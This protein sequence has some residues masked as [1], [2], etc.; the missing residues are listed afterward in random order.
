VVRAIYYYH[1]VVLEWGDIGYNLL[2]DR[3]GNIY[4]GRYG[5]TGVVG[6][7][8]YQYNWGSLGVA[9][10][11]NFQESTPS[12]PMLSKLTDLLAWRSAEH[13]LDPTATQFFVD[14]PL[15]VLMGHRDAQQTLCPGDRAY[16]QLPALRAQT[17]AKMALV[18][19]H[20]NL[21]APRD[22]QA[23]RGVVE[24]TIQASAA[25][26]RVDYYLDDALRASVP[27]AP[28]LWKWNTVPE[29]AGSHRLRV[30]AQNAAGQREGRATLTVDNTP[31]S[32]TL[33]APTWVSS[34]QIALT[35]R[36][37]DATQAQFS[38][39]WVWEG[40]ALYHQVL[41]GRMV[42]DTAATNGLAW[43]GRVG[44]DRAGV[45]YGPY[46]CGIP[47]WRSYQALFRLKTPSRAIT[48][49]LATLDVADD[50]GRRIYA[51]RV[52]N[53]ADFPR[54]NV[55]EEFAL[56]FTYRDRWPACVDSRIDDGLEF[57]TAFRATGDLTLDRVAVF[58]SPQPAA[59]SLPWALRDEEGA[60]TLLVRLLDA[61]GNATERSF[62]ITL[63]KTAPQWRMTGVRT[64]EV[65]DTLSGLN[66][67][68][69]AYALSSD[70]GSSWGSWQTL[71]L[72]ATAG[73]TTPLSLAVPETAGALLR[74]RVADRAG[75]T[76]TT[77]ASAPVWLP[78]IWRG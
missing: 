61:A 20:L 32:G 6:G 1:A 54:E 2:V 15:P 17:L 11:G 74:L 25:I 30:V 56:P 9:L 62:S 69:A 52:L 70:G 50:Q 78:M 53:G 64:V 22:G 13:Y 72:S 43:Q 51:Q 41:S 73:V 14:Q 38:N 60:Q 58:A 10:V 65:Q 57:R 33:T 7:H 63:D 66:P 21:A 19:P 59:A 16:A 42:S 3:L 55:Y 44:G 37:S 31:P 75:N 27:S 26:S 46:S 36:E 29:A 39:G 77:L 40:E 49:E 35:L 12:A 34:T 8:A 68:T 23:V 4:E 67:A 76:S 48:T 71:T 5:G 45:W 18:P 28:F 24:V 47:A